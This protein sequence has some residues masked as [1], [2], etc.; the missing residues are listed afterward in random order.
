MKTILVVEDEAVIALRLQQMLTNMGYDVAGIAY[1]GK[2]ALENIRS[3]KPDLVLMDIMLPGKLDGIGVAEIVQLELNIPVIFLTAFSEDDI[4]K[5]ATPTK[6][7]LNMV[8][9]KPPKAC[10]A[11]TRAITTPTMGTQIGT[12][13]G[14]SNANNKPMS[15]ALPS[16]MVILLSDIF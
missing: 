10:F 6:D 9:P 14:K 4:I 3:L 2:E 12:F 8:C 7:G 15:T 11:N 16:L 13:G 1:S 5:K